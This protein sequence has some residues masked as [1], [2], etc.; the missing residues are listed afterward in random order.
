MGRESL[1]GLRVHEDQVGTVGIG[2]VELPVVG[3]QP[4]DGIGGPP[5]LVGLVAGF[6]VAHFHLD[7]GP[8][9]ARGDDLLLQHGPATALVLDNLTGTDQV[10]LLFH[11]KR[12][13]V[14]GLGV[15]ASRPGRLVGQGNLRPARLAHPRWCQAPYTATADVSAGECDATRTTRP[16]CRLQSAILPLSGRVRDHP[17]P[18]SRGRSAPSRG[19]LEYPGHK[20]ATRGR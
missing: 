17:V 1:V 8:A 6:E 10:R 20:S 15:P 12:A 11:C 18:G 4:L 19:R 2:V 5:A 16:R 3:H 14:D 9:L 7:E 13:C